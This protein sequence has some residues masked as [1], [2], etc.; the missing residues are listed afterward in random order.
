L[1]AQFL[2]ARGVELEE[3]RR[4]D[5]EALIADQLARWKP[6]TAANRYRSL[7]V[8]YGWLE[9]EA[10]IPV[11][12]MAKMRPPAVPDQPVPLVREDAFRRLLEACAGRDFEA[13]R[14]T[15][16]ILLL[17]DVGP[18]RAEVAGMRLTDLDFDLQVAL[19]LGK[20]GRHAR[21]RSAAGSPQALDRYLRI[22]ARH[23]RA[24]LE[25]L[26]IGKFGRI[27]ESGIAQVLR[28]RGRQAGLEGLHPHQLRH[29]FAIYSCPRV[30][31]RLT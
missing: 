19:V 25:W 3:A 28:R 27:T 18:R 7:R 8:F 20:G 24:D 11:S 30:A 13:R 2:T 6:A 29:T 14:D 31:M 17:V 21:C 23:P 1:A 26:W 10:E 9:A 15:A 12:P 4:E 16:L 22:R 5:I